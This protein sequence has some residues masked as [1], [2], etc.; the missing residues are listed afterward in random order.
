[1]PVLPLGWAGDESVGGKSVIF[2]FLGSGGKR[3]EAHRPWA[4]VAVACFCV[5]EQ[6]VSQPA[7]R[8]YLPG[9]KTKTKKNKPFFFYAL[10]A[11]LLR[12]QLVAPSGRRLLSASCKSKKCF[13]FLGHPVSPHLPPFSSWVGSESFGGRGGGVGNNRA[14]GFPPFFFWRRV[15]AGL[16][17]YPAWLPAL[18]YP[19]LGGKSFSRRKKKV[20]KSNQAKRPPTRRKSK[21]AY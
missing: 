12:C 6:D 18:P 4:Q 16:G 7:A 3:W 8:P 13:F 5:A 9:K 20:S 17:S 21:F 14:F 1:M 2:F 11:F 10:G 19:A 15:R